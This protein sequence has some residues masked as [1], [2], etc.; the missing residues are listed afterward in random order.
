[1]R[2]VSLQLG[3]I[4][5]GKDSS[6]EVLYKTRKLYA[7]DTEP[8]DEITTLIDYM[9]WSNLTSQSG[10]DFFRSSG[11]SEKQ[12]SEPLNAATRATYNQNADSINALSA[13]LANVQDTFIITGG[14][15]RKVLENFVKEANATLFLG[16]QVRIF[17]AGYDT[18]QFLM[19]SR[20]GQE[21]QME[22]ACERVDGEEHKW[23]HRLQECNLG[24]TDP[25]FSY[26]SARVLEHSSSRAAARIHRYHGAHYQR[27]SS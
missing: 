21:H 13:A 17:C 25:F 4:T 16:S 7:P 8:W 10:A 24:R 2:G 5:H 22:L 15:H 12:I 23:I 14:G 18:R 20:Q 11:V 26:F 9:G 1:M 6:A 19:G 27:F 3:P